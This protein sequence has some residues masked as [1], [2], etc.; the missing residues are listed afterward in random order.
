M[1]DWYGIMKVLDIQHL[2]KNKNVLW[3]QQNINNLLH[4]RGEEFILRA[5][6]AGGRV[7]DVIP[8]NYYLGLDNRPTVAVSNEMSDLVGEPTFGG[9]TRQPVSSSG[10]FTVV[11]ENNHY[12]AISVIVAFQATSG[13]WGPVQ[14]LFV[15]NAAGTDGTL[16]S[17][18]RLEVP[19]VVNTGE[20][21]TM[22]IGMTLKDCP[23][24]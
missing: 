24:T 16:I 20:S 15:A 3:Q 18:A 5:V 17:T 2:D 19:V 21:V 8:E 6:F 7:S 22:R 10:D 9:Y 13:S 12:I 11:F 23:A 1:K 4:L 14:N